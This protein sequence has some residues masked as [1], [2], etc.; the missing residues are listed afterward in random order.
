[1]PSKL[2]LILITAPALLVAGAG[3]AGFDPARFH[4][5][6]CTTCH[7]AGVYTRS[8]RIVRSLPALQAQVARC[9]VNL[10]TGLSPEDQAMLVEH[11]NRTHYGFA[12]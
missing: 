1:M 2:H 6:N 10:G 5:T 3:H 8:D 7:D 4:Q 9:D 11:L 12:E